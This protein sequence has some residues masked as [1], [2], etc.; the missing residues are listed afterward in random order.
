[1]GNVLLAQGKPAEALPLF[2]N[3]LKLRPIFPEARLKCTTALLDLHRPVE[4]EGQLLQILASEPNNLEAHRLQAQ[5]YSAE[6]KSREL[7]EQY[8]RMLQLAPDWPEVLNN[9]AWVLATHRDVGLRNGAEAVS[10]AERASDLTAGTNTA[11]LATLAAAYAEAGRFDEAIGVQQ[12]VCDL[13]LRVAARDKENLFSSAC[14]FTGLA[15]LTA[16][17][18]STC[19]DMCASHMDM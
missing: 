2:E 11:F 1:M 17:L 12:K 9:L 18:K 6:G 4:A 8:R 3:A 13:Q 10:M 15:S 7:V 16:S 19:M 5:I 14:S